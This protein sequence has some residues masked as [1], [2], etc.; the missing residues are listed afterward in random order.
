ME[1][2]LVDINQAGLS[3]GFQFELFGTA[4]TIHEFYANPVSIRVIGVIMILAHLRAICAP[5]VL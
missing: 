1:A 5:R 3:R 2:L 4:E